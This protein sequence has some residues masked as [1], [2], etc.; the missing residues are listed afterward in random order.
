MV[1]AALGA[2]P[3]VSGLLMSAIPYYV[4]RAVVRRASSPEDGR[5]PE[6]IRLDVVPH[7]EAVEDLRDDLGV[8]RGEGGSRLVEVSYRT[9]DRE[10]AA[11]VVNGIVHCWVN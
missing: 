7:Y 2:I 4:T 8:T 6:R 1:E 10:M 11:A 9:P 3:A 5:A